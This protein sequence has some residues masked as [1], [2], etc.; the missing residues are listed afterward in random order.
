MFKTSPERR[1]TV[2]RSK[3]KN[4]RP[5]TPEQIEAERKYSREYRRQNAHRKNEQRRARRNRHG[6][7]Q[8]LSR[9]ELAERFAGCS[10]TTARGLQIDATRWQGPGAQRERA[11]EIQAD[12]ILRKNARDEQSR[13]HAEEPA[14]ATETNEARHAA[15]ES[16]API[17]ARSAVEIVAE[18]YLQKL[19]R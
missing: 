4:K 5:K 6:E 3:A 2:R 1:A 12:A 18:M 15:A 7:N 10:I 9:Q 13:K 14:A 19:R 8:K 11:L 17:E 16:V